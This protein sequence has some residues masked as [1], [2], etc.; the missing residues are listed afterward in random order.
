M[1]RFK[2][3][4]LLLCCAW[5]H[6][7]HSVAQSAT[8]NTQVACILF[9]H[10]TTCHHDGGIAPFSLMTYN[11]AF[12]AA[13]GVMQTV[14]DRTMPPWPPNP[15]YNHLAHERLLT[16]EEIQ[17]INDWVNAGAP[18]GGGMPPMTPDHTGVEQITN[19]DLVLMMPEYTI[20]TTGDD[21]F[22]CFVIPNTLQE[23]VYMTGFEV[24]PG[25]RAAVHHVM[26]Y[27]DQSN[28]PAQLD[29]AELG[30]GYTCFG[31]TGSNNSE[32]LAGWSPGQPKKTFPDGMGVR[33]PA[34]SNIIMQVHYP[35]TANGQL[36]Q[37]KVNIEYTTDVLRDIYIHSFIH[38]Y[39][40][41]EGSLIIPPN[42]VVTFTG[43]F[44]LPNGYDITLLDVNAHM[45][46]LG[47]EIRS[48]ATLPNNE[49]IPFIEINDWNFN[50]Q[51]FYSF[52]QPIRVPGGTV[53][54]GEATYDNTVNNPDNPFN[55]P[56]EV[57]AGD[58]STDEMLLIYFSYLDY[59]PGDENIIIDTSTVHPIHPCSSVGITEQAYNQLQLYPNPATDRLTI[60]S[61]RGLEMIE[62][63]DL[64]GRVV[65][66]VS[67][68]QSST[69]SVSDL[70]R[71]VHMV[72]VQTLDGNNYHASFYKQ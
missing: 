38:Q 36:D 64:V 4:Y 1:G 27:K 48:W 33:I 35:S 40:L 26:L 21:V 7:A 43:D 30:P 18:E 67:E 68:P 46:L 24:I 71:G 17:L 50:W 23:D 69:I 29:A 41:N 52:R 53:F 65:L 44:T 16:E 62:I 25:N 57:V 59:Q 9:E 12:A 66:R 51:G 60:A 72:K 61:T 54:H 20:S 13:Y 47:K 32:P 39:D 55:P 37:T 42:E 5:F 70:I 58:Q 10:C 49:T 3:S 56:Q 34:G 14:N 63:I 22:R 8:Y 6:H 28:V 19:P 45:H 15:D 31:A 11:D 2:G